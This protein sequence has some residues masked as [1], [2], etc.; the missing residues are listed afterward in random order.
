MALSVVVI[1]RI[2]TSKIPFMKA[3]FPV[4]VIAAAYFWAWL[5]TLI[6]AN[7]M[8]RD[9]FY[10]KEQNRMLIFG[11]I[12]Y[13][14]FFIASFPLFYFIDEKKDDNWGIVKTICAALA[15]GMLTLFMLDL[16]AK[17]IGPL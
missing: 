3:L 17:F 1:R 4:I 14:S 7:P 16:W 11:S 12:L 15:A 13:S 2:T 8:L 5:E 9:N 10:Y 6:M